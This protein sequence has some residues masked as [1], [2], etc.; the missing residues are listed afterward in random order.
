MV[1]QKCDMKQKTEN[2]K[3]IFNMI[4]LISHIFWGGSYFAENGNWPISIAENGN[5]AC[6]STDFGNK[7]SDRNESI[8]LEGRKTEIVNI[9]AT[10]I[11]NYRP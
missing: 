10:E 8:I 9:M 1:D 6:N 4:L 2:W 5:I 7:N 3:G 11:G